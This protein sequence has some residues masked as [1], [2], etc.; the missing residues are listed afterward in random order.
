MEHQ[1]GERRARTLTGRKLEGSSWTFLMNCVNC[2]VYCFF[3]CIYCIMFIFVTSVVSLVKIETFL[4]K[5]GRGYYVVYWGGGGVRE[6]TRRS[7]GD[8][9]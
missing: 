8:C 1:C 6:A 7:A 3:K 2:L 5:M 9:V 4:H